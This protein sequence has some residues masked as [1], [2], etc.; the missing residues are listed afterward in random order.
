[1]P[2]GLHSILYLS[3]ID[4]VKIERNPNSH[5]WLIGR[6]IASINRW[7]LDPWVHGSSPSGPPIAKINFSCHLLRAKDLRV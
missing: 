7:T 3:F 4:E 5:G 2:I 6:L 1:M